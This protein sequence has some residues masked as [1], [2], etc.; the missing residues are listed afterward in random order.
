MSHGNIL[1][2]DLY[3]KGAWESYTALY[4]PLGEPIRPLKK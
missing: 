4:Q 2:T 1:Y 3:Q